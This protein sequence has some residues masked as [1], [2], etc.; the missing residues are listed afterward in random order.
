MGF[1]NRKLLGTA[2]QVT[3]ILGGA[4]LWEG[5]KGVAWN[6]A[7]SVLTSVVSNKGFNGLKKMTL[8][9]FVG[10]ETPTVV[11]KVKSAVQAEKARRVI[12]DGEFEVVKETKSE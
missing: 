3:K 1:V 5:V 10:N 11:S 8:N 4:I 6:G 2:W 7:A 12:V 9:Q